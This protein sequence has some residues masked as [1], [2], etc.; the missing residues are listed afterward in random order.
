MQRTRTGGADSDSVKA[1]EKAVTKCLLLFSPVHVPPRFT[2]QVAI[3][4][5]VS[6]LDADSIISSRR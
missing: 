1:L 2:T 6:P 4:Q 3:R 5:A